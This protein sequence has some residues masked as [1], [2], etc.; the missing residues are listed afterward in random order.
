[1]TE[2]LPPSG[3]PR[4][5]LARLPQ[6]RHWIL[7][8]VLFVV[9]TMM[10]G[11]GVKLVPGLATAELVVDEFL[12]LHHS[13]AG[14][15]IALTIEAVLSPAGGVL[16]LAALFAFLLVARRAP[17]NA[18][19]VCSAGAVGWLASQVFK[20][21]VSQTRPDM[22]LLAD[23]LV[24]AEVTPSFPSGHTTLA[25]ALAIAI[26]LLAYGTRWAV[27]AT[28]GGLV[29]ALVVAVSRLYLGVHYLSDVIGS[30][31]VA[32]AAVTFYS[33]L[34]NRYGLLVLNRIPL[35]G[36]VGPVPAVD[37]PLGEGSA[38]RPA[39]PPR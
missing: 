16:I 31:L 23:P 36:R 15:A 18:F 1:M 38:V 6:P 9:A 34:W 24:P 21:L 29:L 26:W 11:F 13:P 4:T 12:S 37:R 33:G 10:L 3:D 22:R 17:V 27:P 20:L 39:A 25:V 5:R 14:N 7:I 32:I 30:F 8:P 19:A 28:I 2:T 35:L